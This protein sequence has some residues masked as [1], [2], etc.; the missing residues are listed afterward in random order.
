MNKQ[1]GFTL[2]EVMIALAVAAAVLTALGGLQVS[3][4][5]TTTQATQRLERIQRMIFFWRQVYQQLIPPKK[6]I[7][8]TLTDPNIKL[9]YDQRPIAKGSSLAKIED[10][11]IE[12]VTAEWSS[13]RNN[14]QEKIVTFRYKPKEHEDEKRNK[15]A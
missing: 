12:Q 2:I 5:R 14:R 8:R 11:V 10:L 6:R 15:P 1:H 3:L 4:V 7:T 9:I 13:G